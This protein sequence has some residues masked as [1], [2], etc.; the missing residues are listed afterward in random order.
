M[1]HEKLIKALYQSNRPCHGMIEASKI[2]I[3]SLKIINVHALWISDPSL[4]KGQKL[5]TNTN[6]KILQPAIV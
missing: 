4:T 6:F 3:R 2:R 5:H 1:G